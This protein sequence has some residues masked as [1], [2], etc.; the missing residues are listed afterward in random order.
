MAKYIYDNENWTEFYWDYSKI[1]SI[2]SK[3]RNLQGRIIGKMESLGFDLQKEASF[4]TLTQDVIKTSEIEGEILNPEMVRS[5]VANRLGVEIAGLNKSSKEIDGIVDMMMDAIN[6]SN[7]VLTKERLF[8]WHLSLFPFEH[9]KKN[10]ILIGNWRN[11][12]NGPMQ[13]V[14]DAMG[15]EVVHFQAPDANLLENEMQK[16]TDWYNKNDDLD[17]VLKSA[18]SHLWFVTLHPFEDGN[19]RI[20]RALSEMLLTRSDGTSLRF[21]SMSVQICK[22]RNQYYDILE[23]SQKGDSDITEWVL[24]YLKTLHSALLN[25]ETILSKVINKHNFWSSNA[26]VVLNNRQILML[27]KLLDGFEGNL[28]SSKWAKITKCSQD[29]ALRDIQDLIDKNILEKE[30]SGGRSTSYLVKSGK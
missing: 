21:Y 15:K 30:I 1:I 2:L 22:D 12:I 10:R 17:L 13:V 7:N 20:A 28:T 8:N 11:D 9:L 4:E 6:Y 24:W 18:I 23:S 5:S 16:F 29:T 14:S 25:S 26:K 27:N 3:V 19:G